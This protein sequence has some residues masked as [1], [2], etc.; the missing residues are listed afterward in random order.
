MKKNK[1][2]LII[3]IFIVQNVFGQIEPIIT[4]R[5]DQTESAA[6]VPKGYFQGEHGFAINFNNIANEYSVLSSLIRFG[7]NNNFELRLV[8][9]P[10]IIAT[11]VENIS[12]INP[13]SIGLKT[14]LIENDI[15]QLSLIT[16]LQFSKIATEDFKSNYNAIA[17]RLTAAHTLTDFLGIGY[18]IGVEWDGFTGAPYYIYTF[19]SGFAL[20]EKFGAFIELFGN[21]NESFSENFADAGFT[22]QPTN[23]FQFDISA[24]TNINFDIADY[25]ASVGFSYRFNCT[26]ENG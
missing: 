17:T 22:F 13:V 26:K 6:L 24:G 25:F 5:P 19:T 18:N 11:E 16:H 23:N 15:I 12:G 21:F 3:F 2:L 9:D 10:Q 8:I 14:K 1:P 7:I 20:G 4:D